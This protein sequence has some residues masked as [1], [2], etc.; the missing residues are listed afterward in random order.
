MALLS[1]DCS[2]LVP[3]AKQ[4]MDYFV[5]SFQLIQRKYLIS[6]NV[7]RLLHLC[8]DKDNYGPLDNCSSFVFKNCVVK[9]PDKPLQQVVNCYSERDSANKQSVN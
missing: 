7:H 3:Y 9:K 8:D 1:P 5:K 6:H 2:F 4:L